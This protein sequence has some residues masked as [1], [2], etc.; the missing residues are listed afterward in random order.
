MNG[1]HEVSVDSILDRSEL[2]LALKAEKDE[3]NRHKWIESEKAGY[4][5][6]FDRA[7]FEWI[8]NHKRDFMNCK[9]SAHSITIQECGYLL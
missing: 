1:N 2:F 8:R 3:I 9:N 4:D 6:G 7:M 5:I